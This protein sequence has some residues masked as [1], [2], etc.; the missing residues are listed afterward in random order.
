MLGGRGASFI[1]TLCRVGR[2][3]LK[4]NIRGSTA[5]QYATCTIT[6]AGH[7]GC[8]S[9]LPSGIAVAGTTRVVL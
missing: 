6:I 4:G 8:S 1:L 5:Q 7:M 2:V 3:A 9:Q